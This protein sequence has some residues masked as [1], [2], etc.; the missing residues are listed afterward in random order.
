MPWFKSISKETKSGR[1]TPHPLF[2]TEVFRARID[3]IQETGMGKDLHAPFFPSWMWCWRLP[4]ARGTG[5][6]PCLL[7]NPACL[8]HSGVLQVSCQDI[9]EGWAS[10]CNNVLCSYRPLG[11]PGALPVWVG[12]SWGSFL[13]WKSRFLGNPGVGLALRISKNMTS[14]KRL[15]LHPPSRPASRPD[16]TLGRCEPGTLQEGEE[17]TV[18]L[19]GQVSSQGLEASGTVHHV[20]ASHVPGGCDRWMTLMRDS[21]TVIRAVIQRPTQK[22]HRAN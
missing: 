2:I 22:I 19:L 11:A 6:T 9:P 1:V 14:P 16:H 18:G 4:L 21:S 3:L 5:L 17:S 7:R 13:T 8:H 12:A 20:P 15:T 10:R